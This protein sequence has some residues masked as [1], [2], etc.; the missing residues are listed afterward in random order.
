MLVGM[1]IGMLIGMKTAAW[2][3]SIAVCM[4]VRE[5]FEVPTGKNKQNPGLIWG[6]VVRPDQK[7]PPCPST[8]EEM[9]TRPDYDPDAT[10]LTA[11]SSRLIHRTIAPTPLY[12][13]EWTKMQQP[14][15]P[16]HPAN[17]PSP[18]RIDRYMDRHTPHPDVDTT[19]T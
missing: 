3:R 4:Y 13:V 8:K 7:H 11:L 9:Y 2:V 15:P 5:R 10:C 16:L 18:T 17:R 6:P 1:L 19:W 12:D 14:P